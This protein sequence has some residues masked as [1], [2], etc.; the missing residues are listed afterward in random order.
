MTTEQMVS[1]VKKVV[2]EMNEDIIIDAIID[3]SLKGTS[4]ELII[5]QVVDE[6]FNNFK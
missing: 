1:E 6:I 5:E 2:G 3:F 4:D